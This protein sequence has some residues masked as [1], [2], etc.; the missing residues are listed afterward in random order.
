MAQ[1]QQKYDTEYK[2]QAIKPVKEIGLVK[3]AA[4]LGMPVNTLYGWQKA[5][6][7]GRLESAPAPIS[8]K[9]P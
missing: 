6:R 3:V 4:E 5:V 9:W 7:E 8:H 2:I 1:N